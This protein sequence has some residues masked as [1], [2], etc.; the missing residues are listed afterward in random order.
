M[1]TPDIT[2]A[3]NLT[4][5]RQKNPAW[6][7]LASRR[8]P[9]ILATLNVLFDNNSGHSNV[10]DVVQL[11]AETFAEHGNDDSFA[12]TTDF[13][14]EARR[15]LRDWI[16]RRLV[17]EREGL[18]IA[19]DD[20]QQVLSFVS[21]IQNRIMTST[22]SRL[23]TVQREIENLASRL[24][25]D[26]K[27]RERHLEQRIA[28]LEQELAL[29][30]GGEMEIL[31][32][33][34]AVEGIREVFDLAMSLRADFRRVEDSFR[35]ADQQLRQSIISDGQHRGQVVDR[36]LD[37]HDEL[38]NTPEGQVFK[39]FHQQLLSVV[40]LNEMQDR[41]R[42]ITANDTANQALTRQQLIDLR[43]L[44]MR[45]NNESKEVLRARARSE[46]DVKGFLKTGL[47]A[48]HHRVGQL[49]NVIFDTALGV[50]WE[51]QT[52]RRSPSPLRCVGVHIS[53]LPL[54]QRLK[55]KQMSSDENKSLELTQQTTDLNAIDDSFWEAFDSLDRQ[56]LFDK[57]QSVLR[58]S[59]KPMSIGELSQ[60]IS[61]SH[62]LESIAFWLGMAQQAEVPILDE[63]ERFDITNR[64]GQRFLFRVPV[65]ELS[66]QAVARVEWEL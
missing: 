15:E 44:I 56:E 38:L 1:V 26:Q 2:A 60:Q 20:L 22:G 9:L 34:A 43:G 5:L 31:E 64:D 3:Q 51:Q 48:E 49:L 40:E 62:D 27:K 53:G 50:D 25:P 10:D 57:T 66:A 42:Q 61:A 4:S 19:T 33:P 16:K 39:G 14:K 30:R 23:S 45:L 46:R 41:L 65:V 36:L 29:V 11:L 58:Q 54:T 55:F 52:I 21:G 6:Q 35:R 59:N 18:L 7:L 47:A 8:A 63:I 32:G 37:S 12:D 13:Y 17:V 28:Q 24:D